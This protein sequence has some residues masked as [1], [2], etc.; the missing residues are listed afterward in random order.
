MPHNIVISIL[1]PLGILL[2]EF[3]FVIKSRNVAPQLAVIKAKKWSH[4]NLE[5]QF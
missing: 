1:T 4:Q 5:V 3:S 2:I